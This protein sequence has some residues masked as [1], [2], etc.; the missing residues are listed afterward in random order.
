MLKRLSLVMLLCVLCVAA[1]GCRFGAPVLEQI[2]GCGC[3]ACAGPDNK[4][5]AMFRGWAR[6]ARKQERCIDQ[7]FLNYD[8]ND[9]YRMDCL[10]GY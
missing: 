7:N 6:S 3:S 2:G 5:K 9:P 4:T 8:I 1:S 10:A